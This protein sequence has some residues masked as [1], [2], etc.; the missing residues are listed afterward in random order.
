MVG[1]MQFLD[2]F[3][4]SATLGTL[5]DG[6]SRQLMGDKPTWYRGEAKHY[7]V[8]ALPLLARTVGLDLTP[9]EPDFVY[10]DYSFPLR[11]MTQGER[12]VVRDVQAA[13]PPDPYFYSLVASDF[14]PAWLALAR[15]HG[16]QT[17]LLDVTR[18]LRVALYFACCKHETKDG[19]VF[20]YV[21][22][23]NPDLPS[24]HYEDLF[25]AAL[26][27][28][29]AYRNADRTTPGVLADHAKMLSESISV[30]GTMGYLFEC[31]SALND[32][33]IAQRGA[34]IWRYCWRT[35]DCAC[36]CH[37]WGFDRLPDKMTFGR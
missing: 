10:G 18:D 23:W 16:Y 2:S 37:S 15:H 6:V 21:N 25:D 12:T 1:G 32:R 5:M 19:L 36:L 22:L 11:V 27:I 14:D 20:A 35:Q 24:P 3:N 31:N 9:L 28:I 17:R 4:D 8:P 7:N 26:G 13:R 33:M 29:P 34:F 30:R